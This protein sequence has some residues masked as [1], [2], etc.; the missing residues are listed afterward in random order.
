MP[1]SVVFRR[2]HVSFASRQQH[3][4]AAFDHLHQFCYRLVKRDLDW[5]SSR[6]L[7]CMRVLR[8]GS[9]RVCGISGVRDRNGNARSHVMIVAPKSA[10]VATGVAAQLKSADVAMGVLA[11]LKSPDVATGLLARPPSRRIG[12][13]PLR[14]TAKFLEQPISTIDQF[15]IND[16]SFGQ[17]L[18]QLHWTSRVNM[19]NFMPVRSQPIRYQHAMAAK[20]DSLGAHV[21]GPRFFC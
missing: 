8:Q 2:I 6:Q 4:I 13:T 21:S 16:A 12:N 18:M 7:N 14:T 10:D 1:C 3:G 20:V 5:L 17:E 15:P 11:R 9:L 19:E